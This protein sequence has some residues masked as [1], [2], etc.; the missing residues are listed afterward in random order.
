MIPSVLSALISVFIFGFQTLT[1]AMV[2]IILWGIG[3]GAQESILKS[4]VTTIVSK[5]NRS[6]GFGVFETA[7]GVCWFL[8]SWVMARFTMSPRSGLSSFRFAPSSLPFRSSISH[9][10]R[11]EKRGVKMI[12]Y[13]EENLS[14]F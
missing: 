13:R 12:M 7:F 1:A 3:M 5:E 4:V 2:G 9:G 8:G 11:R 10:V 6:T 14:F